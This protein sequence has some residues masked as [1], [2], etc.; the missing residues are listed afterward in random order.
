MNF[1]NQAID[2]EF[3]NKIA[4]QNH[5]NE[6]GFELLSETIEMLHR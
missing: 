4:D 5:K 2:Q 6:L 1:T 3:L